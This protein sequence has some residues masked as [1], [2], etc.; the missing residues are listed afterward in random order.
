MRT[1]LECFLVAQHEDS[2]QGKITREARQREQQYRQHT[3]Q[4][5]KKEVQKLRE[6]IEDELIRQQFSR[7]APLSPIGMPMATSTPNATRMDVSAYPDL[8]QTMANATA[9]GL[10]PFNLRNTPV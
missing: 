9:P 6:N 7:I 1:C 2:P 8:Y 4:E 3:Q 10:Q 5:N